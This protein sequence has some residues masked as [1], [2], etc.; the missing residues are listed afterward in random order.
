MQRVELV[1]RKVSTR[2][3]TY[4]LR[5]TQVTVISW[6]RGQRMRR[7]LPALYTMHGKQA[8]V[9]FLEPELLRWL[10]DFRPDLRLRWDEHIR[11]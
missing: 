4:R 10:S 6:R 3:V 2:E 1:G 8:R 9:L 11:V 5:V 7:P